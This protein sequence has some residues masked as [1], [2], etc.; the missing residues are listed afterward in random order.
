MSS[1]VKTRI[2]ASKMKQLGD[3]R[4][5]KFLSL[6]QIVQRVDGDNVLDFTGPAIELK[7]SRALIHYPNRLVDDIH[8]MQIGY[9]MHL[10]QFLAINNRK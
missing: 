3:A 7:I 5:I 10:S 1:K 2:S 4:K 6:R 9:S 8:D